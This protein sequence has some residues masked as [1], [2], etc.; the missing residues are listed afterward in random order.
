[1]KKDTRLSLEVAK[2]IIPRGGK[3]Q[4]KRVALALRRFQ[5]EGNKNLKEEIKALKAAVKEL[6]EEIW[7]IKRFPYDE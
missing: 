5:L 2:K 1:M 4:Q 7:G 6:R 3:A